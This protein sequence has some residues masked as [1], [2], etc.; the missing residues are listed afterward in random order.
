MNK[1]VVTIGLGY[2]GLPTSALI[3]SNGTRV[4]GVDIDKEVVDII[5]NGKIHIV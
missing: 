4:V 1:E 5:T 2:I 3:A